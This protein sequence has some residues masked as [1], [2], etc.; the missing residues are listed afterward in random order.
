MIDK[1]GYTYAPPA[2]TPY[3]LKGI[4]PR[5]QVTPLYGLGVQWQDE[6]KQIAVTHRT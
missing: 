3:P 5:A 6:I 2:H 4:C 1:Y